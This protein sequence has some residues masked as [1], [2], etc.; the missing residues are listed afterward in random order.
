MLTGDE[1]HDDDDARQV[2]VISDDERPFVLYGDEAVEAIAD[3][4]AAADAAAGATSEVAVGTRGDTP[5]PTRAGATTGEGSGT[6]R[7][8]W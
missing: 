5:P 6:G 2:T 3:A 1:L 7:G 4:E 8:A